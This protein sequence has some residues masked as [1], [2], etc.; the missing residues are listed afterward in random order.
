VARVIVS[1][2]NCEPPFATYCWASQQAY[3]E[4]VEASC[5]VIKERGGNTL[6][7]RL[8]HILENSEMGDVILFAEWDIYIRPGAADVFQVHVAEKLS[9]FPAVYD[10]ENI[11]IVMATHEVF[12]AISD[13]MP[14]ERKTSSKG[15]EMIFLKAVQEAG[16]EVQ[17]L[18][19]WVSCFPNNSRPFNHA[20]G[21]AK[22]SRKPES[23]F[24]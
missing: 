22:W 23:L 10:P 24:R 19:G 5:T 14:A 15:Y 6:W 18:D 11:G 4:R 21:V 12:A 1:S 13:K 9:L 8:P 17:K 16:V 7:H 2:G 3:A 20:F